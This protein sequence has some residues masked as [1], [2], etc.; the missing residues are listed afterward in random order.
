[1]RWRERIAD[2]GRALGWDRA[3]VNA[4]L[5]SGFVL[6]VSDYEG[7]T[8]FWV[9]HFAPLFSGHSPV[10]H[11]APYYWWFASSFALYLAVPCAAV[12]LVGGIRVRDLGFTLGDR[13][14]GF[15]VS[16]ALIGVMVPI[17]AVA[18]RFPTFSNAYPLAGEALANGRI[19]A[20]YEI[21]YALYFVSWEFLFRG[22][23]LQSVKSRLGGGMAVLVQTLPFALMHA[24]KPEAEAYGSIVAGLALG[25]LALRTGSFWYGALIH[26]T[27]AVVMDLI[28]G[29]P[30]LH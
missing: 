8:S 21:F 29:L 13:R 27:I 10:L 28:C 3:T 9:V 17:I 2:E 30:R 1:M 7:A 12:R 18:S 19:F 24:G 5:L 22:F 26:G 25:L 16:G 4:L 20:V 6:L 15:G 23:L 14:L 11:I